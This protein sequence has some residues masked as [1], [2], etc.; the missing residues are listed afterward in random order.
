MKLLFTKQGGLR[1]S[2]NVT[3]DTGVIVNN[4]YLQ[5]LGGPR[6]VRN[7]IQVSSRKA[8]FWLSNQVAWTFQPTAI[9]IFQIL[10][11]VKIDFFRNKHIQIKMEIKTLSKYTSLSKSLEPLSRLITRLVDFIIRTIN[12]HHVISSEE[13]EEQP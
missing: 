13:W 3:S 1:V 9:I 8:I 12:A 10:F 5:Y 4:M 2:I 11:S 7:V 6:Y